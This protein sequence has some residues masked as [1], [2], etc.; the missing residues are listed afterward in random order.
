MGDIKEIKSVQ[1]LSFA[2]INGA[3]TA[4]LGFLYVLV[5]VLPMMLLIP[6]PG[7]EE[8]LGFSAVFGGLMLIITPVLSF[9]IGFIMYAIMA[10]VYNV[11][12]PIIGGIKL[13][14]E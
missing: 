3:I 10:L 12:A 7:M 4:V 2:L 14:L 6:S 1:V 13:E 9:I 11:L 5:V 8:M